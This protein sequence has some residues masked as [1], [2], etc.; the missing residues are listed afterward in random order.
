MYE[1]LAYMK[2]MADL[3]VRRHRWVCAVGAGLVVALGLYAA[4][5]W[6]MRKIVAP[7]PPPVV[8]TKAPAKRVEAKRPQP[9]KPVVV[10]PTAI[11]PGKNFVIPPADRLGLGQPMQ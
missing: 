8:K 10:P 11:S 9:A 5:G 3:W 2:D 7:A 1:R 4:A 6:G